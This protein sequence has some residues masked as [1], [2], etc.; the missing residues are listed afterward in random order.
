MME[1]PGTAMKPFSLLIKPA[2]ADC[3]LHCSYCF[4]LDRGALYSESPYHRM[5]NEI[6]ENLISS[7]MATDQPQYVF[8]WQGGEPTLM[9]IDFFRRVTRL[10]QKY[11]RKG[12]IVANGLQTN[13]ILVDDEFAEHLAKY[14]FL[15]GIS[16]D[17]PAPVHDYYRTTRSGRGSHAEVLR[18]IECLE[19]NRVEFNVL[20]LVSSANIKK[21]GEIYHYLCERGI[22]Y[23]QYIPCVEFDDQA[24]PRPYTVKGNEWGDFLCRIFDEWLRRDCRKVSVR[25]FD[26]I[27]T[28]MVKGT[29][30]LCHMGRNCCQYFVVEYN[31]DVYPCDFFVERLKK[32]G[33]IMNNSWEDLQK[34]PQYLNFGKQKSRWNSQCSRCEYLKYCQG[35]CLKNRLYENNNPGT[36]SWLCEGWKT[37]FQHSLPGFRKLALSI[38]QERQGQGVP[39]SRKIGRNAPCPCGSGKK[40]KRC[41]GVNVET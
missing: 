21:A 13:G 5:S 17:G 26:S 11:G 7:Y 35:G 22:F 40:Y 1:I 2:S 3:N 29:Y 19:R 14:N 24:R 23:H 28:L 4:Y 39:D 31:G 38:R 10:Q 12:T 41:C 15:V 36:L 30:S 6:L 27:L 9:G 32:L 25:L 37:F 20:T 8:G 33:N 16:L 18:A 34:S